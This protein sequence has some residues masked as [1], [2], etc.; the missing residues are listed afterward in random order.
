M[1]DQCQRL[2][3]LVAGAGQ[4]LGRCARLRSLLAS[5]NRLVRLPSALGSLAQLRFLDLSNNALRG[6]MSAFSV[7]TALRT[8]DFQN[9][10]FELQPPPELFVMCSSPEMLTS[11]PR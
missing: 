7:P 1:G 2:L 3:T 8:L 11:C 9:N 4:A 6:T 10:T 5:G